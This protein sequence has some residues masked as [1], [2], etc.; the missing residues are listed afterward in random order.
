MPK[1]KFLL[2]ENIPKEVKKLLE[3]KG[4]SAEYVSKGITNS[5]LAFL[6]KLKNACILTRDSDFLNISSFPPKEFAGIIVFKI[7]PP[8]AEKLV[9]ALS[10]LLNTVSEFNGKLFV[11]KE[12]GFEVIEG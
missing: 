6:A 8:K 12:E 2:D 4:F 1:L 9:K 11:V 7:H 5:E 10:N 3:S